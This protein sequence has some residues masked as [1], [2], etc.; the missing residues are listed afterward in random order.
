MI[1]NKIL[2]R[3]STEKAEFERPLRSKDQEKLND[4]ESKTL[5]IEFKLENNTQLLSILEIIA[6]KV[7]KS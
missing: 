3:S 4:S 7:I 6:P 2:M 1:L 5:L